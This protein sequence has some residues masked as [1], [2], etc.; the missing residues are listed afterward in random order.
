MRLAAATLLTIAACAATAFASPSGTLEHPTLQLDISSGGDAWTFNKRLTGKVTSGRCD[1]VVIRSRNA[2]KRAIVDGQIFTANM[3]LRAGANRVRADCIRH[4]AV[5]AHS[6]T[7]Q[8]TVRLRDV[9]R[10]WIRTRV[11][12]DAI[13]MDAGGTDLAPATPA[14]ITRY[15]WRER[16]GNPAPLT[17]IGGHH[18]TI[19]APHADG[20][21]YVTLEVTDQLGRRD[22]STGTFRI[23]NGHPVEVDVEREHPKWVDS[24]VIYGASPFFFGPDGFRGITNRLDPIAALGTT[25]LW[26]SPVTE[27]AHGDFGYAVTDP[28]RLRATFGTEAQFRALIQAAHARGLRV[29]LDF[30]VNHLSDQHPYYLDAVARGPRS[31]YYDWFERDAQG[32]VMHYFDWKNLEN[33][34]YD[35]PEVRN[36]LIASLGYWLREFHVDGFRLDA[37]WTLRERAPEVWPDARKEIEREDPDV[38]LLA[39]ASARD[40]YY[41]SHGFDAAYDWTGKLGE[42]AWH[43][44]FGEPGALPDLPRLREQLT[45]CCGHILVARFLDNNDTG[46]RFVT[47]HGV[48]ETRAAA[49]LL[50]TVPGIPIIYNGDEV[51]AAFEPYNQGPPIDWHDPYGLT[52]LY[53]RLAQLRRDD[54]ALR[55]NELQWVQ[56]DHPDSVLAYLR[57]GPSDCVLVLLNFAATPIDVKLLDA[58]G[59][60][61]LEGAH[62][63][64]NLITGD[65]GAEP[66]ATGMARPIAGA[67]VIRIA[68]YGAIAIR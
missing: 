30:V 38:L 52:A 2:E 49:A 35:N 7:Q 19:P 32:Q 37:S 41:A 66:Q 33:L 14:P 5:L 42:W 26:L 27:A 53:A 62:E 68:G 36:Y 13:E 54:P 60:R 10:A 15:E 8:W 1:S 58:S 4:G 9:P 50:F 6:N 43:D 3:P 17:L 47:R 63:V 31:A 12:G 16:P 29:L 22:T 46:K 21:Y 44:V 34:N 51:G 25:V 23:Q 48:G 67:R 64:H 11:N 28:F 57:R 61:F 18:I 56:T 20:D 59:A 45:D 55:S 39:E 65:S 24:A 40:P